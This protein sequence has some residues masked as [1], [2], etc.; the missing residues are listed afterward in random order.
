VSERPSFRQVLERLEAVVRE[1]ERS[2]VDLDRAL[3]LFEE[4][5]RELREARALLED[6]E[7]RVRTVVEKA[8]GSIGLRDTDV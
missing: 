3:A 8:D 7:L 5:V 4:G 2:D 1:L 6:A